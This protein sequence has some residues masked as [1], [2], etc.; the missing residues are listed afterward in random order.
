MRITKIDHNIERVVIASTRANVGSA[1]NSGVLT[2][3]AEDV[4]HA[5][6]ACRAEKLLPMCGQLLPS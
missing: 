6:V 2:T 4:V 3:V 1:D 5:S